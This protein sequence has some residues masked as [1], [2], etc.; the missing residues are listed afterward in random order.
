[1]ASYISNTTA[2]QLAM[3]SEMGNDSIQEL[4]AD[5]PEAVRLS[6]D[7]E[8]PPALSELELTSYMQKLSQKNINLDDT[9]CFLGA[10][11]YDHFIPSA[12]GNLIARQEFYTAY[13]PYQPEISQGNLQAIFE[14]QSMICE[15]TGMDIANASM[16][17][18][19]T[20]LAEA[21]AMACS[22]TGKN[23]V[24]IANTVHPESRE[25]LKTYARYKGIMVKEIGYHNG[26]IDL[27]ALAA[28]GSE[29]TAAVIVQS[30]NFFGIIEDL[31]QAAELAHQHKALLIASVDPISLAILK[32]P[33]ELGADIVV[34]DGQ[35]L[36]NPISF[37]GPGLGFM[38]T[39]K[40]LMRK[41]PGR[42]VG[43]TT[44]VDGKRAFVLTLQT[45]EQH[46]RRD[47][48]TSNICSNQALNALAG[49]IYMTVLG[50]EGL[51]EVATL[52]LNKAHYLYD[53]L[54]KSE[55]FAPVFSAP[56]FKEFTVTSAGDTEVLNDALLADHII[57]GYAVEQSYP[58]LKNGWLLA[59]T[60]KR[61]RPEMDSLVEKA[62][63][64]CD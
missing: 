27:D 53:Q 25:V 9:S 33:G 29:Q 26:S 37:G 15:L 43:Q 10:G 49:T 7:L 5:I 23:E 1:M 21:V 59:V 54:I 2:Q 8:L 6:R 47:K 3:L 16:Y 20:A 63:N 39:S 62:V 17:D 28:A 60:E 64:H 22:H 42:V 19:A 58:E 4:F 35:C 56:F 40:A 46:I 57:G 51:K 30:P 48:A 52:C 12:V 55:K 36:G 44:D 61:T 11:A 32:S 45:R 41:L 34:G 18:G 38:A 14:F 13:T 24:L 50:K 31:G